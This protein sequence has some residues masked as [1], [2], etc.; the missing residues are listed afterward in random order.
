[1]RASDTGD[2]T[3]VNPAR[4]EA[5]ASSQ[6]CGQCHGIN[7]IK[8]YV[9]EQGPRFRPAGDLRD[10]RIV[11]RATEHAREVEANHPDPQRALDQQ[12][13]EKIVEQQ[14]AR[15]DSFLRDRFWPDGMVRVSGREQNG[16][17]ES[18]CFESQA[19]SCLTCHSM[20]ES[21]PNDQLALA[22]GGP[23]GTDPSD[24]A[25]LT[26]HAS[27]A[28]EL[29]AHT[30]HAPDSSGSRCYNCH[31]PHTVYGL[32]KSIRSHWV[33][34]PS[35]ATTQRTGRPDACSLCHLD[36]TLAWTAAQLETRYG[37][38]APS[39]S[40][41]DRTLSGVARWG[42]RGNAHQRSMVAWHL[43]WP[44]AGQAVS[45]DDWRPFF[46]G[47]LLDDPYPAVRYG[48]AQSLS[49][50][51]PDLAE[52]LDF[53]APAEVREE[54]SAA[55]MTQTAPRSDRS[56]AR[57]ELLRTPSGGLDQAR[58]SKIAAARDD[59]EMDLRE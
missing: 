59:Q 21:D 42:V 30:H 48:A 15:N 54:Q 19:L 25:C 46:L 49:A 20:H 16:L 51:R 22:P 55:V 26:C 32:M 50:I 38:P 4:L 7:L 8:S 27:F 52:G 33:D 53:L 56:P 47:H 18:A 9:R 41:D 6:V 28:E 36:Q 43:G 12:H 29:E 10:T 34:S 13:L 58:F 35:A 44:D 1:L 11:L 17:I 24:R 3:I 40:E 57:P 39:L 37:Q 5:E 31:M 14:V 23:E 45:E 2:P